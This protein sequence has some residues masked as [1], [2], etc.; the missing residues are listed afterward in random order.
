VTTGTLA[1]LAHLGAIT[2]TVCLCVT[3]AAGG[4][5]VT[6][7][8]WVIGEAPMFKQV[9]DQSRRQIIQLMTAG[10]LAHLLWS[11]AA[12]FR[13]DLWVMWLLALASLG[14]VQYWVAWGHQYML[15][16]LART[17]NPEQIRV[18]KQ[19]AELDNTT[20]QLM[21]AFSAAGYRWL[22]VI[23]WESIG[24][25][26]FGL[27]VFVRLP[28]HQEM[29]K[30]TAK[31][32]SAT[33]SQADAE[34]I[35]I[36][37]ADVLK[38]E[39]MTDWVS[40]QKQPAAG[41]YTVLI[42][43]EDVM[44]RIYPYRDD[45]AWSTI[46]TPKV[47]G[48]QL[49]GQP[50]PLELAQHGQISGMSRWGKSSLIHVEWAEATKCRDTVIW[51]GGV[52][53]LYDLVG[54]WVEPYR[55]GGEPLPLDWIA[56]GQADLLTMLVAAMTAARWR[57]RQPMGARKGFAV[58]LLYLDEAS[59]ALRNT[60]ARAVYQGVAYT[61]ANL[62]AMLTQ[63]AGSASVHVRFVSQR[64]VNSHFGDQGGDT[65][66][67]AGFA[68]VFRTKDIADIGRLTGDYHVAVPRHKGEY[69]LESGD[70][71]VR[72]KAPY[73]QEVDPSKPQLHT[74]LTISDV[75]MS[76]RDFRRDMDAGTA[77]VLGDAYTGRHT[78]MTPEFEAYLTGTYEPDPDELTSTQA[79]GYAAAM[80][81]LDR[82]LGPAGGPE[83]PPDPGGAVI[84]IGDRRSRAAR[85]TEIVAQAAEPLSKGDITAALAA[86]GDTAPDQ[87][88]TNALTKLVTQGEL[89][90]P[91]RGL[92]RRA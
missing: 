31:A 24:Q 47:V 14:A 76:R 51:V 87:A 43:T 10:A 83:Q 91:Q 22:K 39:V 74:G 50:Y 19:L 62:V 69:L 45:L 13:P 81:D 88:V 92:Y 33:F 20:Q 29:A 58:I 54:G 6:L 30:S 38:R 68:A 3:G 4:G 8:K 41:T 70:G 9:P 36:A 65:T 73:L 5:Y 77:A 56:S 60:K 27:R 90:R 82:V 32:R 18:Q 89:E 11:V 86:M 25:P 7:A 63:G 79:E 28:S 12:V 17:P 15:E 34:H 71:P 26:P 67:N 78:R 64:G 61:A 42:V 23:R 2:G 53:K 85:I 52:E 44:A 35:A 21:A 55:G 40:I 1:C 46:K 66:A 59:F 57:Q 49:D 84:T 48:Y 80:A 75:S 16:Q 72:L 37:L